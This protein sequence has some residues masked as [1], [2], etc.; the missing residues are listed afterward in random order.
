MTE[1]GDVCANGEVLHLEG[2]TVS[3]TSDFLEE[4]GYSG[5]NSK[6][7]ADDDSPDES[8]VIHSF[9]HNTSDEAEARL[10][11][12]RQARA[13][14]REIRMREL[15]RQQK[16]QEENADRQFDMLAEPLARTP[17]SAAVVGAATCPAGGARGLAGGRRQPQGV[18]N[19][20]KEVEEKFRKAMIANAST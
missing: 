3:E 9:I 8:D 10:W 7:E 5:D 1:V 2:A 16:E 15:E 11:A 17:R 13:E 20:L 6:A 14:A 18:A 19:K 12:K 4:S